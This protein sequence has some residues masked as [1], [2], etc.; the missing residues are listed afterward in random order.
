MKWWTEYLDV[1][2]NMPGKIF[3][4]KP[5]LW[6]LL[7]RNYCRFIWNLEYW[8]YDLSNWLGDH[9]QGIKLDEKKK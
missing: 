6:N 9:H 1:K 3:N 8:M 5:T 4:W 2:L 7:K